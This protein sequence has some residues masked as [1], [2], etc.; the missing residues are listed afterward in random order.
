MIG[1]LGEGETVF[2]DCY[3]PWKVAHTPAEYTGSTNW[4]QQAQ[5]G[6]NV[7]RVGGGDIW[8][9]SGGKSG[10]DQNALF[11]R[12]KNKFLKSE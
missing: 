2:C 3:S 10:Y 11:K 5:K 8:E 9:E 4:S 1:G 12:L 7:G 6:Q